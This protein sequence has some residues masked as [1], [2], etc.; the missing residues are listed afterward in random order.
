MENWIKG[1]LSNKDIVL[2]SRI[3]LAR[4]IKDIKFPHNLDEDK[5][6]EVIDIVENAFYYSSDIKHNYKSIRLWEN[7]SI[8]NR[9]YL[10]K[11][12]ISNKLLINNKKSAFILN[13]EETISLMIN[14]E[15]H[16]R[17]QCITAGLNLGEAYNI[18]NK[19]DDLL[20]ENLKYAFDEKLGYITACPTNI[21]T[22]MRASVMLHLPTLTIN[23]QIGEVL[24]VLSQVGMTMR[25]LY[26]EGSK[27]IG[28]I[29]Q[30]SNQLSLGLSEEEIINNLK[31]V[32]NQIINQ[33]KLTRD[34][35]MES[36]KYEIE[37]RV[38]RALGILKSAVLIDSFEVLTLLSDVRLGVEMGMINNVDKSIMNTLL[39]DTQTA[40]L[41]KTYKDKLTEKEIQFNRAKLVR[42]KLNSI[43]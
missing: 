30:I 9:T 31:A 12:L 13:N 36:H 27:T 23:N 29:Y 8:T 14:E 4:N 28:R 16:I 7:D 2:S 39:L 38:Y 42:E 1:N 34:K 40:T 25:G 20:E 18:A 41:Q 10:E 32:V 37:D 15:D 5:S 24:N 19:L 33:E 21:G 11:H 6:K 26:G 35:L 43:N 17:L 3:R 22:G